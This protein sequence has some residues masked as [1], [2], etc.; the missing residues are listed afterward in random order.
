MRP[1][2]GPWWVVSTEVAAN[3]GQVCWLKF[4]LEIC[5]TEYA[6]QGAVMFSAVI[7]EFLMGTKSHESGSAG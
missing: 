4:C 6:R 3:E 5:Y 1:T 7:N 2:L